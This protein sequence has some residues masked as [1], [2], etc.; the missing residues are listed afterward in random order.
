MSQGTWLLISLSKFVTCNFCLRC[1]SLCPKLW[2]KLR[3][4]KVLHSIKMQRKWHIYLFSL[5]T[6]TYN[7]LYPIPHLLPIVDFLHS[8]GKLF[9]LSLSNGDLTLDDPRDW[10]H[11]TEQI[12]VSWDD[13]LVSCPWHHRAGPA[14]TRVLLDSYLFAVLLENCAVARD[15]KWCRSIAGGP[16]SIVKAGDTKNLSCFPKAVLPWRYQ[17]HSSSTALCS[18][19]ALEMGPWWPPR[20]MYNTGLAP[21]ISCI[22]G[23]KSCRGPAN[24][25]P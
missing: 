5:L 21:G 1:I 23:N 20:L 10:R 2:I 6:K 14:A 13:L 16:L 15:K 8:T 22:A 11:P 18:T 3:C 25:Y 24:A 12:A 17:P 19:A 9:E 7:F 4:Y